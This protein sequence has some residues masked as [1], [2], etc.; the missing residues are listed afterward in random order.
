M[1]MRIHPSLDVLLAESLGISTEAN[2]KVNV[3]CCSSC[4]HDYP[5]H[6]C[7]SEWEQ[8]SWEVPT[9]YLVHSCPY[10]SDGGVIDDYAYVSSLQLFWLGLNYRLRAIWRDFIQHEI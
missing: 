7:P 6:L 4:S 2:V 8:E 1:I 9:R 10:C 5:L 3:A